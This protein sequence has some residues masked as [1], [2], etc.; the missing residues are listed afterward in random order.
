MK[1]EKTDD[2]NIIKQIE[3][4][5]SEIHI[6]KLEKDIAELETQI[7]NAPKKI[8]TGKYPDDVLALIAEH[9]EMIGTTELQKSLDEK[10][11]LLNTLKGL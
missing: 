10:K 7:A 4:V 3:T 2:K 6:D 9:N 8:K 1:Y 5:T 11:N